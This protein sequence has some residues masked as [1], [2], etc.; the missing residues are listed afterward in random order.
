M[1]L[2]LDIH[3]KDEDIKRYGLAMPKNK[4]R[5]K[6][7]HNKYVCKIKLTCNILQNPLPQN[8]QASYTGYV[9]KAVVQNKLQAEGFYG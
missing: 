1:E 7:I 4:H 8:G 5:L 2:E 3:F 9:I 6:Y